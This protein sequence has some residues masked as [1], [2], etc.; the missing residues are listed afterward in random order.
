MFGEEKVPDFTAQDIRF[1]S[2]WKTLYAVALDRPSAPD[3]LIKSLGT[4]NRLIG[5]GEIAH[6]SLLGSDAKLSWQHDDEGLRISLP[7]E[8]PG[9][10][11]YAFKILLN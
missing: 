5:K 1:T 4:R 11:A 7:P 10:F 9:A 2:R 3:V 6:I 8:N